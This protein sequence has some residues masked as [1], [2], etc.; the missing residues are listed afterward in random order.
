ML[1]ARWQGYEIDSSE[2][3]YNLYIPQQTPMGTYIRAVLGSGYFVRSFTL[4]NEEPVVRLCAF[5]RAREAPE[6]NIRKELDS[7]VDKMRK[8]RGDITIGVRAIEAILNYVEANRQALLEANVFY[9][10][11]LPEGTDEQQEEEDESG[12]GTPPRRGSVLYLRGAL[13]A[14]HKLSPEEQEVA[15]DAAQEGWQALLS[16]GGIDDWG[17]SAE[18][19]FSYSQ[20]LIL[21]VRLTPQGE[22]TPTVQSFSDG[23]VASGYYECLLEW[24]EEKAEARLSL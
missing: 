6:A 1:K 4:W 10:S 21:D 9:T 2:S 22:I 3:S 23:F 14:Y 8:A 19:D 24:A 16:F 20:E 12:Y 18:E 13:V 11:E 7:L 17:Y 5:V 15:L